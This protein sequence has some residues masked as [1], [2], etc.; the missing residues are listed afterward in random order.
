MGEL[1]IEIQE[2]LENGNCPEIVAQVLDIPLPWVLCFLEN[3][4]DVEDIL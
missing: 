2:M 3:E 1:A 4:N